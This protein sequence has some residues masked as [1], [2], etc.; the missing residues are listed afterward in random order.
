MNKKGVFF[1]IGALLIIFVL[2]LGMQNTSRQKS[3]EKDMIIDRAQILVMDHFVRDFDRQYVEQI[4][5]GATKPAIEAL[6][7]DGTPISD[8]EIIQMMKTGTRGARTLMAQGFT[9]DDNLRQAMATLTFKPAYTF[10][11]HITNIRQTIYNEFDVDFSVEYSF[12]MGDSTWSKDGL[13]VTVPVTVYGLKH[14]IYMNIVDSPWIQETDPNKCFID[15]AFDRATNC[16]QDINPNI[17]D[18][19]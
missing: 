2:L 9:T 12:K 18:E 3:E 14:P 11:F 15:E 19:P 7:T 8:P 4:M 13:M 1:S 16:H 10:D 5:N 17:V 6:L